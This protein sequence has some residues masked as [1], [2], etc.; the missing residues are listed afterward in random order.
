MN[1][2]RFRMMLGG[3]FHYWG[4]IRGKTG[5]T[6]AGIPNSNMDFISLEEAME[7]SQQ[8]VGLKD[9]NGKEIYVGDIV[10]HAPRPGVE[11]YI[12]V[13]ED[14]RELNIWIHSIDYPEGYNE[15]IGDIYKP[16]DLLEGKDA[17]A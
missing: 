13:V 16:P 5:M 6:F 10:R 7:R 2:I 11:E 3:R 8:Y 17:P 9:T 4:F 1:E 12:E 14:I 15:I